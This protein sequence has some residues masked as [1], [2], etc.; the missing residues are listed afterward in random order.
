MSGDIDIDA[1]QPQ[2]LARI[3]L[4]NPSS[5]GQPAHVAVRPDYPPFR[6]E[7][8]GLHGLFHLPDGFR[9][10]FRMD[11]V[12]PG[13]RAFRGAARRHSVHGFQVGRQ[14]PATGLQVPFKSRNTGGLLRD[15]QPGFAFAHRPLRTNLL[16]NILAEEHNSADFA[17][18]VPPRLYLPTHPLLA[19]IGAPEQFA[20]AALH[21]SGERAA[22]D[23]APLLRNLREDLVVA[24]PQQFLRA[25]LVIAAVALAGGQVAH[26]AI[27]H[28]DGDGRN[29]RKAA[30]GPL[31]FAD[32]LLGLLSLG[33][34]DRTLEARPKI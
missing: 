3:V 2:R 29:F 30:Q 4:E 20:R 16:G 11:Q 6:L 32:G 12:F 22:V 10:V 1:D 21:R 33:D 7:L 23:C 28:G 8:A 24:A 9:S 14:G 26:V 5:S 17:G 25:Q 19:A 34:I 18:G 27:E 13:P 31:A 15:A